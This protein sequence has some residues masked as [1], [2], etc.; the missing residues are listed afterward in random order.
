M[1]EVRLAGVVA[2]ASSF[3]RWLTVMDFIPVVV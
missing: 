2:A 3:S 1:D